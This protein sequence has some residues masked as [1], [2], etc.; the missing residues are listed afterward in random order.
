MRYWL[1]H[2][3]DDMEV[4]DEL[5]TSEE[6]AEARMRGVLEGYYDKKDML[7]YSNE[8]AVV[9][10]EYGNGFTRMYISEVMVNLEG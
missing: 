2:F 6:S 1:F 8:E 9:N 4:I 10:H 5:Y 7:G 3:V